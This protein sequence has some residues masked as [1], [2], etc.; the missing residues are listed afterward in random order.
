MFPNELKISVTQANEQVFEH[1]EAEFFKCFVEYN[2]PAWSF[3]VVS[4]ENNNIL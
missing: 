3:L 4:F 1:I 2:G